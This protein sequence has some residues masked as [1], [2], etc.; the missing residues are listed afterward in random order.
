MRTSLPRWVGWLMLGTLAG[1]CSQLGPTAMPTNT[2]TYLPTPLPS[3]TPVPSYQLTF[4]LVP[5]QM[6][7]GSPFVQRI[8]RMTVGCLDTDAPCP[9]PTDALYGAD[10][11]INTFSWSS[12]GSQLAFSASVPE[13]SQFPE[14]FVTTVAGAAAPRPVGPA[15]AAAPLWAADGQTLIFPV[16]EATDCGLVRANADGTPS[17]DLL[18]G[19]TPSVTHKLSFSWSSAGDQITFIGD[20]P[21]GRSRQVYGLDLTTGAL[22]QLTA[23]SATFW[24]PLFSPDGQWISVVRVEAGGDSDVL[25]LR[26]NGSETFNLTHGRVS[27]PGPAEWSP[28]GNW[29]AL[30]GR[31]SA[32]Q[33]AQ[34]D[35]F[36]V[37]PD[38]THLTNITNTFDQNETSVAW[39]RLPNP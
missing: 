39:R 27:D 28:E 11:F 8:F 17:A 12:D 16:C 2:L 14:N 38:G 22:S 9:G 24:Q 32:G 33:A 5:E 15:G 6:L 29:L 1:A 3:A 13:D 10:H 34:S 21:D 36:L 20:G 37:Q 19:L 18:A 30:T 23:E 7:T 25:L 4:L 26:A 31:V 35:I